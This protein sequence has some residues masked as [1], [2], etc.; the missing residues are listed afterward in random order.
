MSPTKHSILTL[1]M[2]AAVALSKERVVTL[3]GNYATAGGNADGVTA[4]DADVGD[5]VPVDV[6]GTQIVTAGGAI[7]EHDYVEVG[8]DGKVVTISTG[9]PIGKARSAATA[10]GDRIE[11]FFIPNAPAVAGP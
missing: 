9:I 11:I 3:D 5:L 2:L 8:A 1:S 7:D 4:T 10:D 6:L